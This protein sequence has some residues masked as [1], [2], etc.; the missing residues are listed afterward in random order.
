MIVKIIGAGLAGSEAAWQLAKAG[1]DVELYEMRPKKMTKAHKTGQCAELVCS[2]SFR[3]ASLSNAVGLLKEELKLFNSLIME[4]A[5]KHEVPA[6][7][8]LAVDRE[9]FSAEVENK[10]RQESRI[11]I[12]EEEVQDIPEASE[13]AP[14]IVATGPLTSPDMA[15]SIETL[16]GEQ[17]LAFFD[18]ISPIFLAESI[19]MDV[20]F[21]QSR[22]D[23]GGDDYLNIPLT[24]EQYNS[25]IHE[26][27]NAELYGGKEEVESDMTDNLKPFEGCM[28][29]EEM[30]SRGHDTPRFGP[31][32]P[33]GLSDKRSDVVP[34][35][36]IQLRMDDSEGLRWSMVGMQTKMRRHEQERI[37]RSLPG[38]N[39]AE[40]VRFGSL[41]RNSFINSP[42][43]L[44]P[45]L[46]FKGKP[47]LY[48]AGQLT[49]VEGY[50]E[51]TAGGLVAGLNVARLL[52]NK[53]PLEF[54]PNTAIGSL[55]HYIS[56]PSRKD[57][58]PIN[59]SFGLMPHYLKIPKR[60]LKRS[61]R[62]LKASEASL[63]ETQ[64]ML[65]AM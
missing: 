39:K 35:A 9:K 28:P 21:K 61:E 44:S 30:I 19:D 1:V 40:F 17:H 15:K 54:S 59:V 12:I 50:V 48:F 51:S 14:V 27:S 37:F 60:G 49:G 57:F 5:L 20:I 31:M 26:V 42:N 22:Y 62:R 43:C 33:V 65:A 24:E 18:A 16:T 56:D 10:L 2:N 47:G 13:A 4:C 11:K 63:E 6:G 45:S 55:L 3:G 46:S 64:A 7:G 41:H 8:A 34:H 23:K 32:K 58:Q 36:V 25:F 52:Q 53:P 29:I 38:M